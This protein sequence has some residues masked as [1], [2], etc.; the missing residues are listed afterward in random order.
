MKTLPKPP[1]PRSLPK[2]HR[3][4]SKPGKA[5]TRPTN[6]LSHQ[7]SPETGHL[8]VTFHGGRQYRYEGVGKADAEAFAQ[9]ESKGRHLNA[10]IIGKFPH[11]KIGD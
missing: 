2:K 1:K 6:I 7:Y 5:S 8:T 11:S 4:K 3:A 9:A 10:H